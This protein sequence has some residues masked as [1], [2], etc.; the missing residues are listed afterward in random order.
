MLALA[1]PLNRLTQYHPGSI[2]IGYANGSVGKS[3]ATNAVDGVAW[4]YGQKVREAA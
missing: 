2:L 1:S 4:K 3:S